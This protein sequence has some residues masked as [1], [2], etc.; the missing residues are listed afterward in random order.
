M[1]ILPSFFY[2]TKIKSSIKK[3]EIT[4]TYQLKDT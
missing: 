3:N 2:T 4:R 1:L